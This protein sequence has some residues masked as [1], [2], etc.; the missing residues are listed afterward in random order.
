MEI[1]KSQLSLLLWRLCVFAVPSRKVCK[2]LWQSISYAISW[3][4][5]RIVALKDHFCNFKQNQIAVWILQIPQREGLNR[6]G[7]TGLTFAQQSAGGHPPTVMTGILTPD[8]LRPACP[9]C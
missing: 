9:G 1:K 7:P 2:L 4:L 8:E 3:I 5:L 6:S